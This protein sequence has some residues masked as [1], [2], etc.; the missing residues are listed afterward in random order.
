MDKNFVACTRIHTAATLIKS[1]IKSLDEAR[2]LAPS[3]DESIY[4]ELDCLG[5][6]DSR[7]S[8]LKTK[9]Y[10]ELMPKH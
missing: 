5:R 7:L 6:L 9:A 8:K 10:E 1:A 2:K 4:P 3:I